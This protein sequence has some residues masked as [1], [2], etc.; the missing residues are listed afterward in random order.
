M[1]RLR[2]LSRQVPP[3]SLALRW[4]GGLGLVLALVASFVELAEDVW[5]RDWQCSCG[6][7]ATGPGPSCP[8]R[9]CS[10]WPSAGF[11]WGSTIQAMPWGR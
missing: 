8:A 11:T 6:G 2:A 7:S 1:Q 3:L 10:R 4:L 9:G 5:F